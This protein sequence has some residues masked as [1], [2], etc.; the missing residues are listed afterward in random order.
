M[1]SDYLIKMLRLNNA[2]GGTLDSKHLFSEIKE[3]LYSKNSFKKVEKYFINVRVNVFPFQLI[4][5]LIV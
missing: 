3:E 1:T 4:L 5:I 2:L